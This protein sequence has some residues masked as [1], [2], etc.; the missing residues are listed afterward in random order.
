MTTA[1]STSS[2][3]CAFFPDATC[4]CNFTLDRFPELLGPLSNPRYFPDRKSTLELVLLRNNQFIEKKFDSHKTVCENHLTHLCKP[5][6]PRK[7][8]KCTIC[9]PVMKR[10]SA[11]KSVSHLKNITK[12]EA[13]V[14]LE[15]Y[16]VPNSYGDIICAQYRGEL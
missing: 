9:K 11:H 2:N 1:M 15:K 6:D 10:S 14:L 3:Q 7:V 8:K 12:K 5:K 13:Y 4:N 16:T